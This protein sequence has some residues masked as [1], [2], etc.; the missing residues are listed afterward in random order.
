MIC[1]HRCSS[2]IVTVVPQA[3]LRSK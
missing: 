1:R 2:E 3:T